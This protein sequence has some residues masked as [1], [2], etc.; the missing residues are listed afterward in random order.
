MSCENGSIACPAI[1]GIESIK[2]SPLTFGEC[3]WLIGVSVKLLSQT[4][5]GKKHETKVKKNE[6][7]KQMGKQKQKK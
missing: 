5:S 2:S 3:D 6:T 4:V 7:K 1:A